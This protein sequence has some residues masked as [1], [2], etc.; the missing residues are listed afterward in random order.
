MEKLSKEEEK[1]IKNAL[2][3]VGLEEPSQGFLSNVMQA[4]EIE[5]KIT[6]PLVGKKGWMLLVFVFAVSL[7]VLALYPQEG[8]A[9]FDRVFSYRF[10]FAQNLFQEFKVSKTLVMGISLLGL[11]LFQL[12]FLI[13]MTNKQR[14]L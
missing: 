11:F 8:S 4:I 5:S 12:P 7:G 14:N 13:K 9:L 2:D 1:V 10:E 3:Q 6:S